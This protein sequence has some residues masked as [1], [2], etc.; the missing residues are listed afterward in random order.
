MAHRPYKA[1]MHCTQK[2]VNKLINLGNKVVAGLTA[3]VATYATPNPTVAALTTEITK[4]VTLQGNVKN[5]G[6]DATAKR[7]AEA[8]KVYGML[9]I[10]V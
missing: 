5:G 1:V 10:E 8:L 2:Q 9:S 7:D 3:N 6:K 4:L